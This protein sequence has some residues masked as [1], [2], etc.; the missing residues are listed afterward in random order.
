MGTEIL[1]FNGAVKRDP[2]IDGWLKDRGEL[3]A[4]AKGWFKWWLHLSNKKHLKKQNLSV[5]NLLF[6]S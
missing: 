5:V 6:K 1:R 3:G 2:G 4:I